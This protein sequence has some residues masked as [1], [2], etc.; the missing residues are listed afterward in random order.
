VESDVCDWLVVADIG[1]TQEPGADV[2]GAQFV[3]QVVTVRLSAPVI[4][5]ATQS[6]RDHTDSARSD[7]RNPP[8]AAGYGRQR[9]AHFVRILKSLLGF[10]V[11]HHMRSIHVACCCN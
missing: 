1:F 11:T 4:G 3:A 5:S 8:T 7:H 9:R 10:F 2:D 6:A